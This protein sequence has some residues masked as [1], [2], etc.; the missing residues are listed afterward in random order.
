MAK[1]RVTDGNIVPRRRVPT[2]WAQALDDRGYRASAPISHGFRE[3]IELFLGPTPDLEF[4]WEGGLAILVGAHG[5]RS[6]PIEVW[7]ERLG[8]P[9]PPE[10]LPGRFEHL[11]THLPDLQRLA[12]RWNAGTTTWFD[13]APRPRLVDLIAGVKPTRA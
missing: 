6:Y 2:A 9:H 8:L 3:S 13:D 11:I 10:D 12:V 7:A 1:K 5:F 4:V